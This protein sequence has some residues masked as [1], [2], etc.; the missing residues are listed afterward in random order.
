MGDI[1]LIKPGDKI[2]V[3]GMVIEGESSVN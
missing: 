2:P 3:V 1:V